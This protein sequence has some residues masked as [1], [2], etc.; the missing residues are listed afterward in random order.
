MAPFG[1][2]KTKP[3]SPGGRT[4]QMPVQLGHQ[5]AGDADGPATGA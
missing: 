3:R 4:A 1:P 2:A 5:L